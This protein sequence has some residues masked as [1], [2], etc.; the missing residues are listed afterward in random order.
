MLLEGMETM[1]SKMTEKRKIFFACNLSFPVISSGLNRDQLRE[2]MI[3]KMCR[4]DVNCV[5]GDH[6]YSLMWH[7]LMDGVIGFKDYGDD[8][9]ATEYG[10]RYLDGYIDYSHYDWDRINS[11]VYALRMWDLVHQWKLREA[12]QQWIWFNRM[13]PADLHHR[14]IWGG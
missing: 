9:V 12:C 7:F 6:D 1:A 10:E 2:E 14:A 8:Y 13:F 4:E 11:W 3:E 5:M